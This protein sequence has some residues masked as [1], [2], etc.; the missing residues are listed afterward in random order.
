MHKSKV[1]IQDNNKLI[2]TKKEFQGSEFLSFLKSLTLCILVVF[3]LRASIVEAFKIPS[4]SM[5]PTLEIGDQ[6]LVNKLSYGLRMPLL[7]ETIFDFRQP[8]RGDVVVFTL[9]EDSGTNIIKRIIGLPGDKIQVIG[10]KVYINDTYYEADTKYA[11]WIS[12]GK[13]DFGP[14]IVPEGKVL[15]LGDNRDQSLDSRFWR[16]NQKNIGPNGKA[17]PFL[18]IKRIKGRAFIIYWNSAFKFDHL[19]NIIR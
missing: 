3:L 14:E 12:D 5:V 11:Q 13:M 1:Q 19:F 9:P 18:D 15:L 7:A 16:L 8:Q 10:T 4:S 2:N 6:I 17:S